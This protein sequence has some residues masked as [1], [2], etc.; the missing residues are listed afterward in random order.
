MTCL[1]MVNH[2]YPHKIREM[3]INLITPVIN[4]IHIAEGGVETKDCAENLPVQRWKFQ[5]IGH[6]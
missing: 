3:G 1:L 6:L 5:T 2:R 4:Y